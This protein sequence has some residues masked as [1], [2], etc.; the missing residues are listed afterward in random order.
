VLRLIHNKMETLL[1]R[2]HAWIDALYFCPHHPDKGFPGEIP[3]L[4]VECA[5]RKPRTDMFDQAVREWNIA[6]SGSYGIGD[7]RRDVIAARRMGIRAIGVR[8]G[9]GCRDCGALD[10]PDHLVQD[11]YEA[12]DIIL[13]P[14]GVMRIREQQ[15]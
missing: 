4:K 6:L 11:L 3:D 12:V 9:N 13:A 15:S 2:E 5:C 14:R 8:T 7:S 10:A 1:G